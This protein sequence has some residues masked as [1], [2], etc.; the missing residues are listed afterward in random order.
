[1]I[2]PLEDTEFFSLA[3]WMTRGIWNHHYKG[4]VIKKRSF[5][6]PYTSNKNRSIWAECKDQC[7]LKLRSFSRNSFLHIPAIGIAFICTHCIK[8]Y[9]LFLYCFICFYLVC[10]YLSVC[11]CVHMHVDMPVIV[12]TYAHKDQSLY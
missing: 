11:V 5:H 9:S 10:V 3:E 2:F 8:C 7:L 6:Q 4:Q 1:M 12:Y